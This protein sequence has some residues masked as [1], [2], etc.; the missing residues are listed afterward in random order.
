MV[1]ELSALVAATYQSHSS[2]IVDVLS[3]LLDKA[4]TELDDARYAVTNVAH[5]FA[6][7]TQSIEDQLAQAKKGPGEGQ[8]GQVG[9][10]HCFG[11]G[12]SRSCRGSGDFGIF[13]GVSGCQQ[14][15]LRPSG[16]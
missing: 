4:Q 5:N 15:H 2:D 9:A 10:C 16:L 6:M 1:A 14:E 12:E 11:C 7:L 8:G 13:E 3:E